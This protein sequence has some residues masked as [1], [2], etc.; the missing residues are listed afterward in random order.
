MRLHFDRA[1]S[2]QRVKGT[3]FRAVVARTHTRTD[4]L[5]YDWGAEYRDKEELGVIVKQ[6]IGL[7]I[8]APPRA[9]FGHPE[10][11]LKDGVAHRTIGRI[12]SARLDGDQAVV[13]I[14]VD[15]P[16]ALQAID[17]GVHELSLGYQTL[18]GSD[19]YQRGTTVD[20]LAI[21]PKGNCGAACS[22]H[23]DACCDACAKTKPC[24]GSKAMHNSHPI[25]A[26]MDPEEQIRQL[27]AQLVDAT[28][29]ADSAEASLKE[30][31]SRFDHASG[32]S[33]QLKK[34]LADATTR[35][36]ANDAAVTTE[37]VKQIT[38]RLD[39]ANTKIARFDADFE[40]RVEK[41]CA[42]ERKAEIVLGPDAKLRGIPDRAVRAMVIKHLDAAADTSDTV[43]DGHLEG[44]FDVL[45]ERRAATA[46]SIARV[47]E[48]TNVRADAKPATVDS[49][50]L[51]KQPLPSMSMK[52]V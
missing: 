4:A 1:T 35:L 51:W 34:D 27:N 13:E 17:R 41:R 46:R 38:E 24:T 2:A 6:L 36:A 12:N 16:A 33:E 44:R 39:A 11:L 8:V 32:E 18:A 45:T 50:Q 25:G 43:S 9:A 52:G 31:A 22:I 20:H 21:V 42:L 10:G 23:L 5:H 15:D 37:A 28:K 29:R 30:T 48:V 40:T 14:T 49:N 3:T 19:G 47:A 7:P 26:P